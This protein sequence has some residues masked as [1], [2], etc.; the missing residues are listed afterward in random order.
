VNN[1]KLL[2]RDNIGKSKYIIINELKKYL[3]ENPKIESLILGVSGGADSAL[4]AALAND[5]CRDMKLQYKRDI[6]LIGRSM[7]MESNKVGE[8]D[9]AH[10]V[11]T[12]ICDDFQIINMQTPYLN[13]VHSMR[14]QLEFT[15][16]ADS[17]ED[18][19]MRVRLG[20]I[21]ARLRMI[22][23]Y[24][25]ASKHNGMV[26]STDNYTEYLLGFWTLHGDV[27]DYG[28]IQNL[29]KT[30]VFLMLDNYYDNNRYGDEQDAAEALKLCREA[31]PT[32]GLGIT[33][34]DLDQFGGI[35]SYEEVDEIFIEML[36]NG[37]NKFI[38][39]G[40]V[41][42]VLSMYENTKFKRNNPFNISRETLL[43]GREDDYYQPSFVEGGWLRR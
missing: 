37:Y 18:F 25:L 22:Y 39:L 43:G 34:S 33:A 36:I 8:T 24:D 31:V 16:S 13:L 2:N 35:S 9:R 26:L 23:L 15:D 5:V 32:D 3:V 30:E 1:Y 20:N 42:K 41:P 40:G 38:Q 19:K 4:V 14:E 6:K 27:G 17:V 21:K 7:P 11:G 29:W 28:M 12:L 10:K